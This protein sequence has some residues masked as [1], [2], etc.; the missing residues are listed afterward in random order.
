MTSEQLKSYLIENI[1]S[2]FKYEIYEVIDTYQLP[3]FNKVFHIIKNNNKDN[4]SYTLKDIDND[5]FDELISDIV[6]KLFERN[7]L[8]QFLCRENF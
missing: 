8:N 1:A 6:Q 3:I 4:Y 2:Y 7:K 5:L